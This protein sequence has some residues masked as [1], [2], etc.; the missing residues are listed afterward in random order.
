M[1]LTRGRLS[2]RV[3]T[4]VVHLPLL[5]SVGETRTLRVCVSRSKKP[6]CSPKGH[7]CAKWNNNRPEGEGE[8]G[9]GVMDMGMAVT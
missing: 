7:D 9:G 1:H 8:S 4:Y 2:P 6:L 5:I 3:A